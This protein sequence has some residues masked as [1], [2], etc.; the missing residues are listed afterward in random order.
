MGLTYKEAPD[1]TMS[2]ESSGDSR[3]ESPLIAPLTADIVS[4]TLCDREG[5][6]SAAHAAAT[7]T[8]LAREEVSDDTVSVEIVS[9]A[10]DPDAARVEVQPQDGLSQPTW[11]A[12]VAAAQAA[13]EEVAKAAEDER[14]EE[15]MVTSD[16]L[17][18]GTPQPGWEPKD[19]YVPPVDRLPW[20][21]DEQFAE[22]YQALINEFVARGWECPTK[23]CDYVCGKRN[24]PASPDQIGRCTKTER[25]S[26]LRH[27]EAAH[28]S[29]DFQEGI[30]SEC[31]NFCGVCFTF[32]KKEGVTK[33]LT[34]QHAMEC[35][36][37]DAAFDAM[38][39]PSKRPVG[40][41]LDNAAC[42][43][44][45]ETRLAEVQEPRKVV[46]ETI[47]SPASL[48]AAEIPPATN[49]EKGEVFRMQSLALDLLRERVKGD[50][51]DSVVAT[52]FEA[53]LNEI[54]IREQPDL[55]ARE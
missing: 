50:L 13:H 15:P 3:P 8:S 45:R 48:P 24:Y 55:V 2:E 30:I 6:K 11:S 16:S 25:E 5:G 26:I 49:A 34:V 32:P 28:F 14:A 18:N 51:P 23:G 19:K 4:I 41:F 35:D 27:W 22:Q 40:K 52:L 1:T 9:E 12:Q 46:V 21:R 31:P 53:C 37:A 36:K 54:H 43:L 17:V 42:R 20:A 47:V 39:V 38:P 29:P 33:H 44:L 7:H 10:E